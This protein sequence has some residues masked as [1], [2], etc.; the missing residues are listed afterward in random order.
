M[1]YNKIELKNKVLILGNG[2]A[3]TELCA[4][5]SQHNFD[6]CYEQSNFVNALHLLELHQA[7][8]LVVLAEQLDKTL[9]MQ[10]KVIQEHAPLPVVLHLDKE[11]EGDIEQSLSLGI[12]VFLSGEVNFERL[13]SIIA[14]ASCRYEQEVQRKQHTQK[15]EQQLS[16]RK[17]IE[18]AKGLLMENKSM[19]ESQAYE[20]LRSSAM[21][22]NKSIAELSNSIICLLYTSPSPRDRG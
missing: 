9:V 5:L 19:S 3:A 15:L 22:Q 13:P 17:I 8:V 20:H 10:L 14:T 12:S 21:S 11:S 4:S 2:F 18:K 16:Q 1:A 7:Q 6:V